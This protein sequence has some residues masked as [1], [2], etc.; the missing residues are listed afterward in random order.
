MKIIKYGVVIL[1]EGPVRVEDW[2]V[3]RE[4]DDPKDATEEQLL[5][6]Y[7]IHWAQQKFD[8]A[9]NSA[10]M[11]VFR[12]TAKDRY[13]KTCIEELAKMEITERSN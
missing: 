1:T 7:A 6:G 5:L 11:D 13:L 4:P 12:K 9:Y 8:A 3:E 2:V 10:A